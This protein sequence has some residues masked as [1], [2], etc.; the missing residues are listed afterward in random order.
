MGTFTDDIEPIVTTRERRVRV[1]LSAAR[2]LTI[3]AAAST[4]TS[5][6]WF[7]EIA[8]RGAEEPIS[9]TTRRLR[10]PDSDN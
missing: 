6:T 1:G 9:V 5:H 3:A 7:L 8:S 2:I 10:N 4:P